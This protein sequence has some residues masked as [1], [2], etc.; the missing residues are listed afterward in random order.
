MDLILWRHAQAEDGEPDAERALTA[1]GRRHAVRVGRWLDAA[2]PE[3]CRV[4]VSPA[5]RCLQT[6]DGLGRR[7]TVHADLDTGTTLERM[8]AACGWPEHG[9]P[10]VLVGHQP[11][12]G[13][14]AAL[15][16]AGAA[17]PWKIPKAGVFWT[18]GG[19][20]EGSGPWIR[21]AIGPELI[22]KLR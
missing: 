12:L 1:K 2:L 5:V 21:L 9:F 6:A 20:A 17:Q 15:I 3:H 19:D 14:L 7:Y 11:Q 13:Q 10:A 18:R 22:G 16:M 8:L 4:L